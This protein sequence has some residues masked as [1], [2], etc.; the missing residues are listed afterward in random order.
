LQVREGTITRI[1]AEGFEKSLALL[2]SAWIEIHPK[3]SVRDRA[4]RILPLHPLRAADA[5]QLAGALVFSRENPFGMELVSL[6][7]RLRE[8]AGKE[9]FTVLSV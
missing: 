7:L 6:D 9:G 1:E 5:L 3:D 2:S 4:R 8:C